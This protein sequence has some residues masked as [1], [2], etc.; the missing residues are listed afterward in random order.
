MFP[1]FPQLNWQRVSPEP[2]SSHPQSKIFVQSRLT[3]PTH[4][5]LLYLSGGDRSQRPHGRFQ[6]VDLNDPPEYD[7]LSYTWADQRGDRSLCRQIYL[8]DDSAPLPITLNCDRALRS[9]RRRESERFIWVDAI[10][11]DQQS[12]S[13]RSHQVGLMREIYSSAATVRIYVGNERW[14]DDQAGDQTIFALQRASA[15]SCDL[16]YKTQ[17]LSKFFQR[18]YFYRLWVVQEVLLARSVHIHCGPWSVELSAAVVAQLARVLDELPPWLAFACRGAAVER[19]VRDLVGLLLATSA[20]Q[21]TDLRDKVFGLLGLVRD[22][23]AESLAADYN[24]TVREVYTGVAAYMFRN[25]GD[26][27]L[28]RLAGLREESSFRK[29]YSIPS[30]VPLWTRH[31]ELPSAES[32]RSDAI[33]L[34]KAC[35]QYTT[36]ATSRFHNRSYNSV[37]P[38]M[39]RHANVCSNIESEI[40]GP[41]YQLE[42]HCETG[43]LIT[44][45]YVVLELATLL[46]QSTLEWTSRDIPSRPD[47]LTSFYRFPGGAVLAVQGLS[48]A[49]SKDSL[50]D[51]LQIL[52]IKDLGEFFLARRSASIRNTAAYG[53]IGPCRLALLYLSARAYSLD[54]LADDDASLLEQAFPLSRRDVQFM[55]VWERI[56]KAEVGE[57]RR[58]HSACSTEAPGWATS[59][60]EADQLWKQYR[61]SIAPTCESD[62]AVNGEQFLKTRW[63]ISRLLDFWQEGTLEEVGMLIEQQ[64]CVENR[65][66]IFAEWRELTSYLVNSAT[67]PYYHERVFA[68]SNSSDENHD[69]AWSGEFEDNLYKWRIRTKQL[70]EWFETLPGVDFLV[71]TQRRNLVVTKD[72]GEDIY[73]AVQSYISSFNS[74]VTVIESL[75][76]TDIIGSA[77]WGILE[78]MWDWLKTAKV[79]HEELR[80][81]LQYRRFVKQLYVGWKNPHVIVLV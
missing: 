31:T 75:K 62:T 37:I 32:L 1:E 46:R 10:C 59:I 61:N 69:I 28:L 45:G 22:A 40:R 52:A 58:Q 56:L 23:K 14:G 42:I 7:A 70:A 12:P 67:I 3:K 27:R 16:S 78:R 65:E 47:T 71:W 57:E 48:Q 41:S 8:G 26:F 68:A 9:L 60:F 13:E 18:P 81:A 19:T 11:I 35:E 76:S 34:E 51:E 43:A 6:V 49:L 79:Q 63:K 4:I 44:H 55:I 54:E 36:S 17:L 80:K 73:I 20:C 15:G 66:N 50:F 29:S 39:E 64:F 74:K 72:T 38:D 30:W 5:R 21:V 24:L 25:Q 77:D 53:I 2:W 33:E